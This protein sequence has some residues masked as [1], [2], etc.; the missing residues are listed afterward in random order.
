MKDAET[1]VDSIENDLTAAFGTE[2]DD[3]V[4]DTSAS[5]ATGDATAEPAAQGAAQA[6]GGEATALEAPKHWPEVDRTLFGKTAPEVQKRWLERDKE[7]RRGFDEKAQAL[8]KLERNHGQFDELFSKYDRDLALNGMDRVTFTRRLVEAHDFL[9]SSP[10]EAIKW[11]ADQYGV[12]LSSMNEEQQPTDPRLEKLDKGFQSLNSRVE[13]FV[14]QQQQQEHAASLNRVGSF[15]E[16]KDAQGNLKRPYFDEVAQEVLIL[17]KGGE[18]DLE[19]AYAKAVRMNDE[20][21]ARVQADAQGRAAKADVEKRKA[22]VEK[23]KRAGV[24]SSSKEV[25]NGSA[26]QTT[27]KDDLEAGFANWQP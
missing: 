19:R 8:A 22:D 6:P 25:V 7:F 9:R 10:K 26:K 2:S 21:F 1:P 13:G 11:L 4:V 12:D 5:T 18:R 16:E 27:L 14:S 23:A 20:V 17:I 15:A 24:T 3:P